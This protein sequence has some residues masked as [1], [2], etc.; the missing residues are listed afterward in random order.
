LPKKCAI[1]ADA[2]LTP[3]DAVEDGDEP[4]EKPELSALEGPF[5]KV[6]LGATTFEREITSSTNFDFL[7]KTA[8]EL[9]A[10]CAELQ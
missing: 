8:T 9:G 7:E 6:F 4:S 5:V 2:D 1:V 10:I 3:S